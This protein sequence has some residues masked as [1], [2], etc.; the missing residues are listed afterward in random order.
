MSDLSEPAGVSGVAGYAPHPPLV[1]GEPVVSPSPHCLRLLTYNIQVGI[2]TERYRHYLTRGWRHV[3][4]HQ[5]R[6][7]HLDRIAGLI[8]EF[9]MVALQEVDAG[10]IRTGFTNQLEYLAQRAGFP[11]TC[12][13]INRNLGKLAQNS[14]GLLSKFRPR[15][16][17]DHKLPGLIPG[18]GALAVRFGDSDHPL[19]LV[20]M[21]L[22]LSKRARMQQMS[23]I[24]E[25]VQDFKHVIVMGDLNC[26]FTRLHGAKSPLAQ[27]HLRPAGPELHTFP[28]W[29]PQ[30]SIDHI[31]VSDSLQ[32]KSLH[33]VNQTLSDHLPVATEIQLPPEVRLV[34]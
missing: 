26:Q 14:N 25:V 33:V 23:Y 18:R 6:Y 13:Q 32:V 2:P 11:F 7:L 27:T 16:V 8:S 9:D 28:S 24:R 34:A 21:H 17:I 15:D 4:P 22:S 30:R 12:Q 20:V 3:L 5:E 10:S 1:A 29:H 19:L 31:L